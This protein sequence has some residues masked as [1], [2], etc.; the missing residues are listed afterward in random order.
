MFRGS[1]VSR[2]RACYR[3]QV[4]WLSASAHACRSSAHAS[5]CQRPR[6]SQWDAARGLRGRFAALDRGASGAWVLQ[7]TASMRQFGMETLVP[8]W[9]S[10]PLG[11]LGR[12]EEARRNADARPGGDPGPSRRHRVPTRPAARGRQGAARGDRTLE[13]NGP[14]AL[15]RGGPPRA[16]R[17]AR[18][19]APREGPGWGS[20]R[21]GGVAAHP[22]P[23][24]G[25]LRRRR[26]DD[27]EPGDAR[28]AL[29][30][31]RAYLHLVE[32]ANAVTGGVDVP[33]PGASTSPRWSGGR[34]PSAAR[35]RAA[36]R[37]RPHGPF[38]PPGSSPG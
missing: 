38:G 15:P 18:R 13:Q 7:D 19:R 17:R 30:T 37:R 8:R 10:A 35:K 6:S 1:G 26:A 22:R 11:A 5:V 36:P 28:R 4:V 29:N 20:P 3:P 33:S 25:A 32:R 24:H 2:A 12:Y 9:I 21:P 16:P 23:G 34:G 14:A 31:S 27:G